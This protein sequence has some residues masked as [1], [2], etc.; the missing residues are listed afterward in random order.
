MKVFTGAADGP[1]LVECA[2]TASR[3][4]Q[5]K[6]SCAPDLLLASFTALG[7]VDGVK[8]ALVD[9][10]PGT[11]VLGSSTCRGLVSDDGVFGFGRSAVGLVAFFDE[12]GAFGT[13]VEPIRDDVASATKA[14]AM[15][16][17]EAA[18][19]LGETPDLIWVHASPGVEE[20]MLLSLGEIFGAGVTIA[21]GSCA[22]EE[23]AG[24]WSLFDAASLQNNAVGLALFYAEKEPA[25][26]FQNGYAPTPRRGK[27]TS[28][29]GRVLETIDGEPAADVYDAWSKGLLAGVAP[30]EPILSKSTWAPLG[31]AIGSIEAGGGARFEYYCLLHPESATETGG[32]ALFAE[33]AEGDTVTFMTGERERLIERPALVAR[34]SMEKLP[35]DDATGAMMVFC[36]GCML[37]VDGDI[38]TIAKDVAA[39]YGDVPFLCTFTFGEQGSFANGERQHGNLMISSTVFS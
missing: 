35:G 39:T 1:D 26:Y 33:V 18:D 8:R 38:P 28:A 29:R 15:R 22:D 31:R 3:R 19:R 20:A 5:E 13:A 37:A 27:V 24:D 16:A 14:A 34:S 12:E 23:I 17:Q 30:G 6:S 21:G 25:H 10:F 7:D 2:L 11:P 32:L 36:A 4:L 9:A